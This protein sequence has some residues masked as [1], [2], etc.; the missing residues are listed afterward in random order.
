M[1]DAKI[2]GIRDRASLEAAISGGAR[3]VGL[4]FFPKSPRFVTL[5]QASQLAALARGR[6]EIVAVTVNADDA[7][8]SALAAH[9]TP[10]WIQ[11][12]GDELPAR[13]AEIRRFA[14]KGVIRALGVARS[15]DLDA[16][17]RHAHTADIFLFDAKAPID[18][19]MPG[20]NGVAFDW[21]VLRGRRF[22]RP[23]MLSGG[24][25]AG[26]L[27]EA[28]RE[29]GA[30]AVDVSSGVESAPGVKDP[31]RIADFL[32]AAKAL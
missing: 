8:L 30:G 7:L 3:Y 18:A 25:H 31:S 17:A 1:I 14:Q 10:D 9:A 12:H 6:I 26:N 23:W 21:R 5:D 16:A 13:A 24:L 11:L 19:A 32:A 28:V 20:G 27:E 15:T 29:S 22:A 2:C 4:N